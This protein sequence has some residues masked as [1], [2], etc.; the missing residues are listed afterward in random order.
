MNKIK[1]LTEGDLRKIV[2]ESVNKIL[3]EA[4]KPLG[5]KYSDEH[6]SDVTNSFKRQVANL[7]KYMNAYSDTLLSN[8]VVD[9][10]CY[11]RLYNLLAEISSRQ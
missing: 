10:D 5:A 9:E 8:G 1:R 11:D 3:S 6:I 7:Q 2:K 4:Y